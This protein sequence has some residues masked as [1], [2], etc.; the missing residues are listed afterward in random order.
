MKKIIFLIPILLFFISCSSDKNEEPEEQVTACF[1]INK[2]TFEIGE[3]LQITNCSVGASS[4]EFNFGDGTT[5]SEDSPLFSYENSGNY[6]IT[7]RVTSESGKTNTASKNITINLIENN[8]LY[9][10]VLEGDFIFPINFSYV[11]NSFYYI[12]NFQNIFSNGTNKYNYVEIDLVNNSFTKKYI[13]DRDYNSGNAFINTLD[14]NNK[15]FYAV[16]SLSDRINSNGI[17]L[18]SNWQFQSGIGSSTKVIY[19]SLKDDENYLYYGSFRELSTDDLY[20]SPSIE[21]RNGIGVMNERK[22]FNQIEQGFIGDLIKTDTGFMAFGGITNPID[23]STFDDYRPLI[24]F[25][26]DSYEY[27][28]HVTYENTTISTTS[29]NDLNGSFHIEKLTNNY[30][31]YSHNEFRI[32]NSTG[33]EILK[34]NLAQ[35]SDIQALVSLDSEG[36]IISTNNYLRKYDVN[37]NLIKSLKFNGRLTPN[38]YL[39]DNQ[40]YFASGYNSNYTNDTGDFSVIK[41][42][43][44]S[45]DKDLNIINLN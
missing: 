5:S 42:F 6:T 23:F 4:Y 8:F 37:G 3:E 44:G 36:F 29:N 19:G 24:I 17:I 2:E 43:I 45:V 16:R 34:T 26:N 21:I 39:K 13:S 9:I 11:N 35:Q 30:V 32:I 31:I 22:T 15:L 12:E 38:L 28:S 14:D 1:E 41:S 10:P 27:V 20:K 25:L 7:L 18:D 40:I 33:D